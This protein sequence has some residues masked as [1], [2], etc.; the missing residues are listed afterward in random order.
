MIQM[1]T[2]HGMWSVQRWNA[3][4]SWGAPP[5]NFFARQKKLFVFCLSCRLAVLL[6]ALLLW[7]VGGWFNY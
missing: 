2:D 1:R 6:R 3:N 7:L 4:T 5:G